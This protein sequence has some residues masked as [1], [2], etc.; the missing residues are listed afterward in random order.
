MDN[1]RCPLPSKFTA[2]RLDCFDL[3]R[4]RCDEVFAPAAGSQALR[5]DR[6]SSALIEL[7]SVIGSW[8]PLPL[9]CR[10]R[11]NEA[12]TC[13][14]PRASTMFGSDTAPPVQ[15][16]SS[17][18]KLTHAVKRTRPPDARSPLVFRGC[19]SG[20]VSVRSCGPF[21]AFDTTSR[22]PRKQV[23]AMFWTH[24]GQRQTVEPILKAQLRV[25]D[26]VGVRFQPGSLSGNVT[27][28]IAL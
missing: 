12:E 10:A 7:Q 20:V 3:V 9:Q 23:K 5:P 11:A 27:S 28:T 22:R 17:T 8:Y 2:Y 13:P 16:V 26:R 4:P 19:V 21:R 15:D 14:V 1:Q 24:R 18:E 25:V 6:T